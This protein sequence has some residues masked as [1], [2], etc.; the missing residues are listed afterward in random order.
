MP[1]SLTTAR[2]FVHYYIN[3]DVSEVYRVVFYQPVDG[4]ILCFDYS[5][6][7]N[8]LEISLKLKG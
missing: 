5:N 6:Q 2:K 1:L 4:I 3:E 8:T 7:E